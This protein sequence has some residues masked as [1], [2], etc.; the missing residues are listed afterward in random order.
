MP[1]K[2]EKTFTR[3][4][5]ADICGVCNRTLWMWIKSGAIPQPRRI[6]HPTHGR[7]IWPRKMIVNWIAQ[8]CPQIRAKRARKIR[9]NIKAMA[10]VTYSDNPQEGETPDA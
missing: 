5:V 6:G 4:E 7:L 9:E 10:A 8:G 2:N 3:Q 1:L